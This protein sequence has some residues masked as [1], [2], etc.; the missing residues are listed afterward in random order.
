MTHKVVL[1]G[2]NDGTQCYNRVHVLQVSA[3]L[4]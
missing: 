2:G 4:F 1:F 3:S